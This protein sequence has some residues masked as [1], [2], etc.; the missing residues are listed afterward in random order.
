MGEKVSAQL[1]DAKLIADPADLYFLTKDKLL[2]LDRQAEKSA[3]NLID[4]IAELQKSA[5][6]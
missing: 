2:E 4:A 6:G 1:F 3:Q 5:S